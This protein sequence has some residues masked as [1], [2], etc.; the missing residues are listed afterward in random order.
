MPS[1]GKTI[2][3]SYVIPFIRPI[4]YISLWESVPGRKCGPRTPPAL[5]L[6]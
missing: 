5:G 1:T 2:R 6:H 3:S 4:I